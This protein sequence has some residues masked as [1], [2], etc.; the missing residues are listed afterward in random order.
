MEYFEPKTGGPERLGKIMGD[1]FAAAIV[2]SVLVLV[3][4]S[5]FR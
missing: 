4:S 5:F 3:L 2:V 1:T